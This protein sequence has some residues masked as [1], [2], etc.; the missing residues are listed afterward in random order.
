L[1]PAEDPQ[2]HAGLEPGEPD[3]AARRLGDCVLTRRLA[4]GGMGVVYEGVQDPPGRVV[5]VKVLR[6]ALAGEEGRLRF[7]HEARVLARLRHPGIAQIYETG[8]TTDD[9]GE[10]L[11]YFVMEH[12][13]GA[14]TLLEH[15]AERGL[16][17]RERLA[18]FVRV[19]EAVHF[20]HTKGVI[21][22]DLKPANVLV[23]ADGA[24]K[25]IDFGIAR[26][27]VPDTDG[28]V[29]PHTETGL[30]VGTLPYMSPEQV[31]GARHDVDT[32][33]DVYA[34]GVILYELLT[35]RLP[36]DLEGRGLVEAA[37]AIA[38][39]PPHPPARFAPDTAGDLTVI[40]G[41]ALAKDPAQR[42]AS[43]EALGQDVGRYQAFVPIHARP[44]S[45]AYQLRLLA[46][47]HRTAFVA[48]SVGLVALIGAVIVSAVFA[49]REAA[50]RREAV[51][52]RERA[53]GLLAHTGELVPWLLR[54]L[55]PDLARL[56][57]S[58]AP[59]ARLA[60]RLQEHLDLLA[61]TERDHPAVL[62]AE[63]EARTALGE[64]LGASVQHLGRRDEAARQLTLALDL[65]A[66]RE[67]QGA[68][69]G[70]LARRRARVLLARAACRKELGDLD[71]TLA[72]IEA[73]LAALAPFA[74]QGDLDA[75]RLE[76]EALTRR[77]DVSWSHG[78]YEASL[79]AYREVLAR[80]TS[81]ALAAVPADEREVGVALAHLSLAQ[82]LLELGRADEARPHVEA[83]ES[84]AR[85]LEAHAQPS[86][87]QLHRLYYLHDN[88]GRGLL[89]AG[90]PEEAEARFAAALAAAERRTARDPHDAQARIQ[91]H[92]AQLLLARVA[93]D[94]AE[95]ELA[96]ERY[97]RALAVSEA[98][99]P[100]EP[101]ASNLLWDRRLALTQCGRAALALG[102]WQEAEAFLERA[103]PLARA[104]A[105]ALPDSSSFLGLRDVW[106]QLSNVDVRRFKALLGAR[107]SMVPSAAHDL[108][109]KAALTRARTRLASARAAL[110][111]CR[112]TPDWGDGHERDLAR[113]DEGLAAMDAAL[114]AR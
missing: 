44:P 102:R 69:A 4:G 73:A 24:P 18:L 68:D 103:L 93:F 92:N 49:A 76:V 98:L 85:A 66:R 91:V 13:P 17:T 21:H 6:A 42:Y 9:A 45:L 74:A 78:R 79:V 15:A 26:S 109:V 37:Q 112:A 16:A 107:F 43:A 99:G 105:D 54:E 101:P 84:E 63:A 55:D 89:E 12:V 104:R 28:H 114:A 2:R 100:G 95:H 22:R 31:L 23:D 3:L 39:A 7:H 56:P 14:R 32:R 8:T 58:L 62:D 106:M 94:R 50:E 52:Q 38:T 67:A 25:V 70:P 53:E 90:R 10:E 110:E 82:C 80:W 35:G 87:G 96:L 86:A 81:P 61:A 77:A 83:V 88:L 48:G 108:L 65:L 51:K 11:P 71:A 33:S 20:G 47:R 46:R 75:R 5:A 19:C 1:S 40:L 36:Y 57:G 59:R 72:D 30:L 41:K 64:M 27:T 34:L 29:A 97:A 60:G 111:R 113:L